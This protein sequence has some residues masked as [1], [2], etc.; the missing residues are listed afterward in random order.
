MDWTQ[1]LGIAAS[2]ASAV[3]AAVFVV[4]Y[5]LRAP[6]WKHNSVGRHMVAVTGVMGLLAV[7]T[8]VGTAWPGALPVLRVL[9]S[10]TVVAVAALLV[11]RTVFVVRATRKDNGD[12][13]S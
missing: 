11:Q 8:V 9:R 5:E 12:G 4:V 13:A 1:V 10:V 2:S 6:A 3:A 7:Y